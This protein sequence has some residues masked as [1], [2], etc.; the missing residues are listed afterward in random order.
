MAP[1]ASWKGFLRLSLV[2]IP[3]KSY[4]ANSTGAEIR[5][6][7][8]HEECHS[9]IKYQ[10]ACPQ[11]GVVGNDEI[12]KGYEYAKD[13]YVVIDADEIAKLRAESDKTVTMEGFIPADAI[14]P[15]FFSGRTSYVA[16]DGVAGLKPYHLLMQTMEARG[17]NALA[18]MVTSG[19]VSLVLVRPL[20]G[21]LALTQLSYADAV[22]PVDEFSDLVGEAEFADAERK[23]TETLID[24]SLLSEFDF[25]SY[26]N[27]QVRDMHKLIQSKVDGEELVSAPS[28]EE[29]KILNLMEALKASVAEAQAAPAKAPAKKMAKSA[30]KKR[31]AASKRK[32]G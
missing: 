16:P 27:E 6:N 29:P 26:E 13:Q 28:Q 9:R 32:S 23:L 7:Q 8:L 10:K 15:V 12:V 25:S 5:L 22:K 24:A 21:I 31:S 14:D 30:R 2:S 4:S 18:R 1:R 11:H 3:V 17:L 19:K 20:D